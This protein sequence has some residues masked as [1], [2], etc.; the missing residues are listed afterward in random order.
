MSATEL[1]DYVKNGGAYCSPLLLIAL[2]WL[3]AERSRLLEELSEREGR[4]TELSDRT[5]TLLAELKMFL[6]HER[7]G[8]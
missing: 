1:F 6:F 7:K 4:I 5:L 2:I 8:G 3:N